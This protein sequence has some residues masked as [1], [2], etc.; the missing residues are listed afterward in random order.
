MNPD[1]T[2]SAFLV[3]HIEQTL[4]FYE[5]NVDAPEGGFY[6]NFMDDGRV[7]DKQTRHLVSSTRFVFNYARAYL[8]FNK[9]EYLTRVES[10]IA[11]I[12]N[13]HLQ[14]TTGGYAWT[15]AVQPSHAKVTDATNHCY[16]L[17]FVILAYS[18]AYRAGLASAKTYLDEAW[19]LLNRHFWDAENGLYKD[20]CNADFTQCSEYRG[21]NANMHTCEALIAAYEATKRPEYLERA[22]LLADH[23]TNRQAAKADGRIWEHYT[24]A[25][26]I[27]WHYN[28]QDPKNLF[29]PWGFQPGHHTE[30]AKLLLQLG[31]HS[32]AAWLTER[33]VALFN[34]VIPL[35]WDSQYGGLYYGFAPDETICDDDKYFWVQA[36]TLACAARLAT[37]TGDTYYWQW[38]DKI[39]AYS[40]Q[41]MVDQEHGAWFRIL[42]NDNRKLESTKSPVGKTDYHTMGACYDIL[43][44][45]G[46]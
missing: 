34:S 14:T 19:Q 43:D 16:G 41:H 12:R 23:I 11:F 29:R 3:Q 20:E 9:P 15:L 30:W 2:Q 1:F 28:K 26:E 5:P 42:G 17:A 27:D 13:F 37:V 38:Y 44:T 10:G 35:S 32:S 39:W 21:Q 6:Q 25:W 36:E 45:L 8:R 7:Y 24:K 31:Q 33:A 22:L 18:W 4:A 46:A 40:W